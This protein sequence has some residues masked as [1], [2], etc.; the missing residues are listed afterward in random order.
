[1]SAGECNWRI[2]G[3]SAAGHWLDPDTLKRVIGQVLLDGGYLDGLGT[4]VAL[5]SMV[6]PV[7]ASAKRCKLNGVLK[8]SVRTGG[9]ITTPLSFSMPLP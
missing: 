3:A 1:M 6:L 4:P 7:L 2:F 8:L 9:S 5:R